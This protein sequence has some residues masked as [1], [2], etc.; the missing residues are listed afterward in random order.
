S[1]DAN[2]GPLHGA[3]ILHD[4]PF[5]CAELSFCPSPCEVSKRKHCVL[6]PHLNID[7]A[8]MIENRWNLT[9]PCQGDHQ[10]YRPDID[11]CVHKDDC[12]FKE[13][14]ANSVCE[15]GLPTSECICQLG[16]A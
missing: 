10:I 9:F 6:E 3:N 5:H 14:P 2:G 4:D 8:G 15:E 1:F 13:C 16:F 11:I 7:L 12:M